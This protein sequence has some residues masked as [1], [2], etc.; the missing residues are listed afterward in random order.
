MNARAR[1]HTHSC[2]HVYARITAGLP[3]IKVGS[4]DSD[5]NG[6]SEGPW[7]MRGGIQTPEAGGQPGAGGHRQAGGLDQ[8]GA[9]AY[10]WEVRCSA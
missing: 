4:L 1:T 9:L 3:N 7:R 5:C 10:A 2:T 8:P 6:N